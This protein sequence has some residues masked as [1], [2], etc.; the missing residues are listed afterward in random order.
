MNTE[1]SPGR[2]TDISKPLKLVFKDNVQYLQ[3]NNNGQKLLWKHSW[4][5]KPNENEMLVYNKIVHIS[6]EQL[7]MQYNSKTVHDDQTCLHRNA[8]VGQQ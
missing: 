5:V 8:H 3:S 1:C 4:L 7:I 6:A 2:M